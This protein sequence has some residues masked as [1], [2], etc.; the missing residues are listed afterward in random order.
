MSLHIRLKNANRHG[1][2]VCYTCGR[3]KHYTKLRCGHFWHG[4]LDFDEE[5][6][7]PQCIYCNRNDADRAMAMYAFSLLAELGETKF[8]QLFARSR[9]KK[10]NYSIEEL[11]DLFSKLTVLV[12]QDRMCL[13]EFKQ[14]T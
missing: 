2:A 9:N 12:E 8:N 1:N 3:L 10:N 14:K 7:K 6:Q 13:D 11:K 5:N 4:T